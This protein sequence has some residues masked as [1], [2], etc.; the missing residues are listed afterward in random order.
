[1]SAIVARMAASRFGRGRTIV[2]VALLL[3]APA[4]AVFHL[5]AQ[6]TPT[7]PEN[8][9]L[10]LENLGY[11]ESLWCCVSGARRRPATAPRGA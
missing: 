5:R 10:R 6:R 9:R 1:M 4:T 11:F 3:L 8:V 2:A 7:L